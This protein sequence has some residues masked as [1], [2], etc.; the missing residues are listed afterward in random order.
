MKVKVEKIGEF[1]VRSISYRDALKLKTHF[2]QVYSEGE[3]DVSLEDFGDLMGH[4]AEV[5]FANPA[6]ALQD[7]DLEAQIN[8]LRTIADVYISGD[9]KG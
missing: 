2:A 9:P 5:A 8:I 3:S 4:V 7:H 6:Q 1:D